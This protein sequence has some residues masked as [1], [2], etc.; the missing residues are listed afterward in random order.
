[1][2]DAVPSL[3]SALALAPPLTLSPPP[4]ET[5]R[6]GDIGE[7]DRRVLVVSRGALRDVTRGA[8]EAPEKEEAKA[9]TPLALGNNLNE[10]GK[11]GAEEKLIGGIIDVTVC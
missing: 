1:M 3:P 11:Q 5:Q 10:E 6:P 7:H 2:S 8:R 9:A 4:V